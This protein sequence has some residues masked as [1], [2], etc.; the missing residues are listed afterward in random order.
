MYL[1]FDKKFLLLTDASTLGLSVI[2]TQ[3]DEEGFE[4][5]IAYA[6]RSLSKAKR[7]YLATE[8]EYLMVV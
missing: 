8:L 3:K 7:N 6:S 2:L 1:K 5:V 4:H